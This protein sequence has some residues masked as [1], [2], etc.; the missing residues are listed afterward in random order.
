MNSKRI[1]TDSNKSNRLA[2]AIAI[3]LGLVGAS[4]AQAQNVP[5]NPPSTWSG[6]AAA[7]LTLTRGNS[8]TVLTTANIQADDKWLAEELLLGADATYGENQGTK[9]AETLHGFGQYNHLLGT[10][11]RLYYGIRA[12][13]LHDGIADIHYRLTL[14][15]LAGYYLIKQ[16]NTT[17]AAEVGPAFVFQNLGGHRKGYATLRLGERFEHKFSAAARLWQSFEIL[18]QVDRF[19]NYLI[20]AELG[21]EAALTKKTALRSYIQDTYYNIPAPGRLKNDVKLVTAIAYKF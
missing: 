18:P 1:V 7:G 17:L 20:N 4:L 12:D 5:T 3:G 2:L 15:P 10:A 9:D 16:T 11:A 13:A 19:N 21:I 8:R 6:S 14:A